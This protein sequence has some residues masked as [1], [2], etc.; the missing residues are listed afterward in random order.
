MKRFLQSIWFLI[1]FG[2]FFLQAR[3]AFADICPAGDFKSLCNLDPN[4]NPAVLTNVVSTIVT[5]LLVLA[6]V[7][8]LIFMIWGGIKWIRSGGDKAQVEQ[9]RHTV[10]AAIVGLIIALL[11]F[12]ILNVVL[13]MVTGKSFGN[14]T[15]P[16]LV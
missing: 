1:T 2:S 15:I 4:K 16:K 7:L 6:V 8:A 11:A 3:F 10:T 5:T 14:F 9:A 12:F 13:Y